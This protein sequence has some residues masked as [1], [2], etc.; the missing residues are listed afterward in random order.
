VRNIIAL[1]G[2]EVRAESEG[3]GRGAT[4][5]VELPALPVGVEA[6]RL[7]IA[8]EDAHAPGR[9]TGVEVFVVDDDPDARDTVGL[10]LRQA[11]ATVELFGSGEALL[12]RLEE[13]LPGSRPDVL[14][15]DLAMPG[16]DGFAVLARVRSID[17][18]RGATRIPAIAVTAFTQVDRQRLRMAGFQDRVGKPVDAGRLVAAIQG[19]AGNSAVTRATAAQPRADFRE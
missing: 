10:A 17:G 3:P 1:H 19:L 6:E 18:E 14:L 2:G 4:F 9:L 5:T 8:G 16:E 13:L 11:G 7:P 15:L 12:V